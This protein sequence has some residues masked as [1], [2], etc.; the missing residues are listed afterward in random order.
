MNII[1]LLES[2]SIDKAKIGNFSTAEYTQI[3]KQLAASQEINSQIEDFDIT[4]LLKALKAHP[5]ALK[6]VLNNRILYNFFT[7]K[8]YPR[9]HFTDEYAYVE[10][11][12]VQ[13]LLQLFLRAELDSFF[14]QN[15]EAGK[16]E[17]I[18]R[19][20]EAKN[21]FPDSLNL[22]LKQHLLDKLDEAI[23][24]LKP[25]YGNIFKVLYIKDQHFF[26]VLNAIRDQEIEQK[27]KELL[28]VISN[29]YR[30]DQNSELANKTFAAMN[31][32]NAI[33]PEFSQ[34]IKSN[35]AISDSN[36]ES[37][38]PKRRN[39]TWLYVV[40]GLFVFI[41]IAFFI[42]S[43]NFND[44]NTVDTTYDEEIEYT[45]EPR[46]M[47]RYY[48]N[49]KFAIDSFQVFL[50]D[51]NPKEIKQMTQDVSLKTGE[52]PFQ[53]FY[54][55]EPTGDSNNFIKVKNNTLYD[56]VLLENTV[57]YDT[58]KIP[59]SALF[60]KAGETLD[61]NFKNF[62]TQTVFNIYLGK[63][64]AT[65]QTNSKHLF[66]RNHSIV[67][68]RFS[69]LIPDAKEILKTDYSFI[70]NAVISYS[71][72]GLDIDSVEARINPLDAYK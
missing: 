35:K 4:Q 41:R 8:E 54:Q 24:I 27:I 66:I 3:K 18:S 65:F 71:N 5:E 13:T 2:I 64:W 61:V 10:T 45:P 9:T 19:L 72:G 28:E 53:T 56:M 44:F 38:I 47:D 21:Y 51:Y 50:A 6:A 70:N 68:Y 48:T 62:D 7:Q 59:K 69:E 60:I 30:Q 43:N 16:F 1:A 11:E 49:M 52:N 34:K 57:L 15:L 46:K 37:Y 32:Y 55:N 20:V 67:E 36:F 58:I 39:L 22:W 29:L 42:K 14:I 26:T 33:D 23:A 25:P 40:V 31:N 12:K 63:K 17:G